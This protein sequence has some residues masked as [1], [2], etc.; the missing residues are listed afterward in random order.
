MNSAQDDRDGSP[1]HANDDHAPKRLFGHYELRKELGRGAQG[2]VYLAEDTQ[3]RRKVALKM[4]ASARAQDADVRERFQREAEL[5]SKLEHPGIC[6]IHEFGQVDGIPFIAMQFI[7]GSP[8]SDMIADARTRG[9]MDASGQIRSEA[10]SGTSLTGKDAM[11][12]VLV[13]IEKAAR[14]LHAAH[15]VGLLHRDIKP[16]NIMIA[17]DGHPVI[18]DFGLARDMSDQGHT[19]TES[20]QALGTP[21]YMSAEQILGQRSAVDRRTDVY[22]L[23]VT[24][25]E[26]LTLHRP[27]EADGFERLYHEILQGAPIGPR[28]H[29]PRIPQDLGTVIEV[30]MDRQPER[31]YATALELAED[32][33]RVRSFEPIHAKAA[34]LLTRTHKWVR[35]KPAPAVTLAAGFLFVVSGGT[36]MVQRDMSDRRTFE[37]SLIEARSAIETEDPTRAL[38]ALGRARDL[39]PDAPRVFELSALIE[40]LRSRLDREDRRVRALASADAARQESV[41]HQRRY[42][43]LR[44]ELDFLQAE[45]EID[46]PDIFANYAPPGSR[47]AFAEREAQLRHL[48]VAAEKL[49][50]DAREALE[51]AARFEAPWGMTD[52][53]RVAFASF[54]M[55]R[56]REAVAAADSERALLYQSAVQSYDAEG[57]HSAELAG[58]GGLMISVVPAH[59]AVHLYRYVPYERIRSSVDVPRLVP[60][61]TT[62]L[63]FAE[64]IAGFDDLA[65]GDA[66]LVIESVQA[67]SLAALAGLR[68]GDHVLTVNGRP[69]AESVF[70]I[71]AGARSLPE[72]TALPAQIITVAGHE[73]RNLF[74]LAAAASENEDALH[75][76]LAGVSDT[77]LARAEE[78]SVV[79]G[80]RLV[81]RGF[82]G[83]GLT[84]VCRRGSE[85]VELELPAGE[86]SGIACRDT[87][88]PLFPSPDNRIEVNSKLLVEPGSY[89]LVAE[90]DGCETL[91]LPVLVERRSHVQRDLRLLPE[92]S[93]PAGFVYVPAATVVLGGDPSAREP[94]PPHEEVI[95]E[96]FMQRFELTNAEWN[97][98]IEDPEIAARIA[99]SEEH[100]YV[101]REPSRRIPAENLGGPDSP[102][103][104][105]SWRDVHDYLEWRNARAR[106][107]GEPWIYDLPSEAEWEWAARGADARSFPWGS[108]FDFAATTGMYSRSDAAFDAPAGLEPRDESPFGIRDLAGLRQEWTRNALELARDAPPIY[109]ISGG[110]WRTTREQEFRAASRGY[111][112]ENF[113]GGTI[114]VRLIARLRSGD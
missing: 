106:T 99:A 69:A 13:I 59:A 46:K 56:W 23:G 76:T 21:A 10:D 4:L 98:F 58:H 5:A 81:E 78:L 18:L 97:E 84:L 45:L 67:D 24:L 75:V 80:R 65:A 95:D 111:A 91:R 34:G 64:R 31:R 93:T 108:R 102:V 82:Q 12:D 20:G 79:N 100:I 27:F 47:A 49:L 68:K 38:E 40:D 16:A 112:E 17:A 52:Q 55:S 61:P 110:S 109:R 73:V 28:K 33:R 26:C 114:G 74:D 88:Y 54:F 14:A 53:T 66:C 37:H 103:M 41:T 9:G 92:R 96:F 94:L 71:D 83:S 85:R 86:G 107:R 70:L 15:E 57:Q 101:P 89:L 30:A 35:R 90:A 77:W 29:N 60:A 113:V 6:G 62:G 39:R 8:L 3:L 43:D 36:V 72:A 19:L 25:Y 44:A 32:L 63:E 42:A 11:Q 22:A 7:A 2:V 48:E 1:A 51:R 50:L 105:V 104:G 87:A